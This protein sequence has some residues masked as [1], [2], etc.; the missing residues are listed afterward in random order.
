MDSRNYSQIVQELLKQHS[1]N[2][3]AN[4]DIEV[5]TIFDVEHDRYQIVQMGWKHQRRVHHCMMHI[6]IRDGKIWLLHNTT[7]HELAIEL[8][9]LGVPKSD[10]VLGFCPP[11]LRHFT[12]FAVK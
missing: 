12:D 3:P 1:K 11:A 10:I 9:D 7:E 4:G 6:D 2:K 8:M 5:E